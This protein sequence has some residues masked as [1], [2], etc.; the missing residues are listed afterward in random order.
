[1][2]LVVG[3]A[4]AENPC[5]SGLKPGQRPGPY[6]SVVSVGPERGQSH[7]FICETADRPA[8]IIFARKLS[9]PLGKLASRL[10]R[11]LADN[12]ARELRSWIT[13]LSDDQPTLDPL[14]VA[15]GKKHALRHLSLSVFEDTG[16]PPTYRLSRDADV[17]V[18]LCVKQ[19]VVRN[20]AFRAGAL[21]DESIAAIVEALPQILGR[22]KK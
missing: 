20:F 19:K 16:G 17:T 8:V 10:D 18:L 21:N 13:F 6:S 2:L 4:G 1:V 5:V 15:W 3:A 14:V 7:C 9:D 12:K 11:A 22:E